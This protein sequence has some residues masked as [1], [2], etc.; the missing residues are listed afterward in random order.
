MQ[1][2]ALLVFPDFKD[3]GIQS[4]T[5]PADGQELLRHVRSLIEPIRPG[6]YLLRLFEAYA[7]PGIRPE[8]LAL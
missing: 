6:E 1:N 8:A 5:H 4:V 7:V 2:L 3:D